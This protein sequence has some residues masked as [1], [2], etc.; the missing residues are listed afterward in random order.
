MAKTTKY[1]QVFQTDILVNSVSLVHK[2]NSKKTA[3]F[4][5]KGTNYK[6]K[7]SYSFNTFSTK[8][9]SGFKR[10]YYTHLWY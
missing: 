2:S 1:K 8:I 4:R 3:W 6:S 5:M 7:M 10:L 9:E